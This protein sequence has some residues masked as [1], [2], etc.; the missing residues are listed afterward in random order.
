VALELTAFKILMKMLV[1]RI[2]PMLKKF[3]PDEQFGFRKNR[4]TL[5]AAEGLI[6]QI[7]EELSR[8]CGKM[9]VVLIDYSKVFDTVNRQTLISKLEKVI[10]NTWVHQRTELVVFRKGGTLAAGDDIHCKGM[11]LNKQNHYRYL[12]ITI[13]LTGKMFGVYLRERIVRAIRSINEITNL[14]PL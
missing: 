5:M 13:Q 6:K 7:Q 12:G 4:S 3:L 8:D 1:T 14:Q 2:S 9:Y 10:G 11:P